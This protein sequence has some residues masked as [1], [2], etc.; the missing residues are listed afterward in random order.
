MPQT[1]FLDL[2]RI[3]CAVTAEAPNVIYLLL[4][5]QYNTGSMPL[6]YVYTL[7]K[8]TGKYVAA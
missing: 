6:Y 2:R 7:H 5:V 4:N 1:V 8:I 3:N